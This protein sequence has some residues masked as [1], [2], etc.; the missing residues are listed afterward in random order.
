MIQIARYMESK[1]KVKAVHVFIG[2]FIETFFFWLGAWEPE[3]GE[4]GTL[5]YWGTGD[6]K[7]NFTSYGTAAKYVA[8]VLLDD[9]VVGYVKCKFRPTRCHCAD[10]I[11]VRDIVSSINEIAKSIAAHRSGRQPQLN[12]LG[13]LGHLKI[14][15]DEVREKG[16]VGWPDMAM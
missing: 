6:E 13:T 4:N 12:P 9:D 10:H 2:C 16:N 7:W 3:K 5:N 11:K 14:K 8:H 1:S 15:T